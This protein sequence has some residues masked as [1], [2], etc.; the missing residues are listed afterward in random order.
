M[1]DS[2]SG[3]KPEYEQLCTICDKYP[4][5]SA[6]NGDDMK[7]LITLEKE[8]IRANYG[9][10]MCLPD[11]TRGICM[12]SRF[13]VNPINPVDV[14]LKKV[15]VIY[16]SC[17]HKTGKCSIVFKGVYNDEK[18]AVHAY[19]F[20]QTNPGEATC[21]CRC[22]SKV[23][24]Y[25]KRPFTVKVRGYAWN[26]AARVLWIVEQFCDKVPNV[27]L[28][29][30]KLERLMKV[31]ELEKIDKEERER[32]STPR[33]GNTTATQFA[34]SAAAA[35][36]TPDEAMPVKGIKRFRSD[37]S[38]DRLFK[39]LEPF[40]YLR[41]DEPY[42][43]N[44]E[45]CFR[46][47]L[48]ATES[49]LLDT[50]LSAMFDPEIKNFWLSDGKFVSFM[51]LESFKGIVRRQTR[52]Y[53]IE[54]NERSLAQLIS[55]LL[56]TSSNIVYFELFLKSVQ[57][58]GYW[59]KIPHVLDESIPYFKLLT[60]TQREL[61]LGDPTNERVFGFRNSRG[62]PYCLTIQFKPEV[63]PGE[64]GLL[65]A[66]DTVSEHFYIENGYNIHGRTPKECAEKYVK[67]ES[68]DSLQLKAAIFDD[69]YSAYYTN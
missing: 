13:S 15:L 68:R 17:S 20:C 43:D 29:S 66:F 36:A 61:S 65:V 41:L 23:G 18:V 5:K 60:G 8:L 62:V 67:L 28:E 4:W 30:F 40:Q 57:F 35:A 47:K 14:E 10:R 38:D 1:T 34:E 9:F 7:E 51:N 37:D 53:G 48:F 52:N 42:L 59:W 69:N 63:I 32:D 56:G 26:P 11:P 31:Q 49:P 64:H 22:Y 58:F 21:P 6:P 54:I 24:L 39:Q 55:K 45:L 16:G 19:H 3:P 25:N 2:V 27:K 46:Q 50:M 12:A 44:D 33:S